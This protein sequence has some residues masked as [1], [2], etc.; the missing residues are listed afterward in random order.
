[1][2]SSLDDQLKAINWNWNS[3][4]LPVSEIF[5]S[6]QGEGAFIGFPRVF[7]RFAICNLR[8]SWCDTRYTWDPEVMKREVDA[9]K[10]YFLT[11]DEI[12]HGS[13]SE[14]EHTGG[15]VFTGGEP[16]LHEDKL[17]SLMTIIN[18]ISLFPVTFEVE[19]NGTIIPK[20]DWA[21]MFNVS[22]KLSNNNADNRQA[23]VV[24]EAIERLVQFATYRGNAVFKFV[25][26]KKEDIE[27]AEIDYIKPF[28]IPKRSVILMPEGVTSDKLMET[29][30][31][32]VNYA[33]E[34]GYRYTP[35]LQVLTFGNRRGT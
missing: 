35:R 13:L 28:A 15:V 2:L 16:L 19:T 12:A 11:P 26:T 7:M 17:L 33:L 24:P 31:W 1:M 25:I 20:S 3:R 23:R 5:T 18:Q 22:P 32:L 30:K 29:G 14:I 8:C 4:T 34:K 9:H 6:I 21:S 27:E 10:I